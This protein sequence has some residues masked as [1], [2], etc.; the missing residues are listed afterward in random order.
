MHATHPHGEGE[1]PVVHAP[2][3]LA[4]LQRQQHAR[5]PPVHL[6]VQL[7]QVLQLHTDMEGGGEQL[8]KGCVVSDAGEQR[9]R[10]CGMGSCRS[11]L[12]EDGGQGQWHQQLVPEGKT[13]EAAQEDEVVQVHLRIG[14]GG[15]GAMVWER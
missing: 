6:G 9:A 13:K 3:R 15:E 5:Q 10:L 12:E 14:Q 8:W 7:L 11:H 4:L 1:P 2:V